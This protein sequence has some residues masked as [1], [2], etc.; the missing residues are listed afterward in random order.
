MTDCRVENGERGFT[1]T[2]L[3]IAMAIGCVLLGAV[4]GTFILQGKSYDAQEQITEMVQT[5]RAAMDMIS[6]EIRMAGY[7]PT[8]AG[9]DGI[10]QDASRIQIIADLS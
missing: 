2:E 7:D 4:I 9:F 3:L 8:G 5:T 1:F 10:P 6:R